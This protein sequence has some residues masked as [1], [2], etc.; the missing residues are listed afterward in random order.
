MWVL[1][2]QVNFAFD[3]TVPSAQ[4]ADC[5][6]L[7]PGRRSWRIQRDTRERTGATRTC[8]WQWCSSSPTG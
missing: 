6:K 8:A 5:D 2:G 3:A 1:A 4:L 7:A